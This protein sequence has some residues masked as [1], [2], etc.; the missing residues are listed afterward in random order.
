[1]ALG[2]SSTS[3]QTGLLGANDMRQP[4][5]G[6]RQ[7]SGTLLGTRAGAG[8]PDASPVL[9]DEAVGLNVARMQEDRGIEPPRLPPLG[10]GM[11]RSGGPDLLRPTG[12][13]APEGVAADL[14]QRF[15]E[16]AAPPTGSLLGGRLDV[17]G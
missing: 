1:M 16:T 3:F 15:A 8:N 17:L 11:Q 14:A 4:G 13:L 12:P 6:L 10:L 2:I 7:P 9:A 5:Q